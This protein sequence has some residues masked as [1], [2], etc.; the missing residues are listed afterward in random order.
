M[1]TSPLPRLRDICLG[2]PETT[3]RLS[4]GAPTWFIQG[5]KTFSTF[6][7]DHHGDGRVAVWCAAPPGAQHS[8]VSDDP[9]QYFVPPY[10][11]TRGW[12]GVRLDRE[13]D[14]ER[15]ADLIED[16]YRTVAPKKLVAELGL[17]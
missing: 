10:V 16:A 11:G 5:K 6:T 3:E 2:M 4:H 7:D 8:L 15:V 9:E 13:P 12:L 1:S 14:W 17:R